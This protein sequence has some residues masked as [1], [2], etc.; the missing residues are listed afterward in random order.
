MSCCFELGLRAEPML[1]VV[2][3]RPTFQLPHGI[4]SLCDLGV[5]VGIIAHLLLSSGLFEYGVGRLRYLDWLW[6]QVVIEGEIT[7][8]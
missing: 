3:G 2:S 5:T 7:A 6:R 4:G 1:K 8:R